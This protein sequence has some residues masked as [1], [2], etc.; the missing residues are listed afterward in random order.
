[1]KQWVMSWIRRVKRIIKWV[2]RLKVMKKVMKVII[3]LANIGITAYEFYTRYVAD[4]VQ[5]NKS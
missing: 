5:S 1:M 4:R 3:S 2:K